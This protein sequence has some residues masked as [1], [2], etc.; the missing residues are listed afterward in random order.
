MSDPGMASA[1]QEHT[2]DTAVTP[3]LL[4]VE[5]TAIATLER[6]VCVAH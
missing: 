6:E 4:D 3:E 5:L 1:Q 2:A